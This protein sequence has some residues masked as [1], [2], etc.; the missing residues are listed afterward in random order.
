MV[1]FFSLILIYLL[2]HRIPLVAEIC[3][4]LF[5][6]FRQFCHLPKPLNPSLKTCSL[7]K[8]MKSIGPAIFHEDPHSS[9]QVH[10]RHKDSLK[11]W[12]FVTLMEKPF[13]VSQNMICQWKDD[14]T[15]KLEKY[16]KPRP[17]TDFFTCKNLCF[18]FTL[19]EAS[20]E[21]LS[22]LVHF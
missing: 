4:L 7:L 5:P 21:S 12:G 17:A 14:K 20:G 10:G 8:E 3:P 9:L 2:R 1:T 13:E 18:I 6:S 19:Q 11:S 22:V 15:P 16:E